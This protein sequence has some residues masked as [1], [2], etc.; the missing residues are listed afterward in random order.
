MIDFRAATVRAK[1]R[2]FANDVRASNMAMS[3]YD[4]IL[5]WLHDDEI[6]QFKE[7][8]KQFRLVQRTHDLKWEEKR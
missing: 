7:Y 8:L 1:A 5:D 4:E 2:R 6:D 3:I